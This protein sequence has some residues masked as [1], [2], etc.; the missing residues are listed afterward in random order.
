MSTEKLS[1]TQETQRETPRFSRQLDIFAGYAKGFAEK[2]RKSRFNRLVGK[3]SIG[4]E[5]GKGAS[6]EGKRDIIEVSTQ[7][8]LDRKLGVSLIERAQEA[9][10]QAAEEPGIDISSGLSSMTTD[11]HGV[12]RILTIGV[13]RSKG[14]K[15]RAQYTHGDYRDTLNYRIT[16]LGNSPEEAHSIDY[17]VGLKGEVS[18]TGPEGDMSKIH[19]NSDT[20]ARML[21]QINAFPPAQFSPELPF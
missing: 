18:M 3:L 20:A 5:M 21:E 16:T 19:A 7:K 6:F 9:A 1:S 2:A 17:T 8:V 13:D 14:D 11:E 4:T 15:T 12:K 10:K